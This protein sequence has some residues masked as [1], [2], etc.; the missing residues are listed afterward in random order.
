L[1]INVRGVEFDKSDG[2]S[3]R[4]NDEFNAAV[5]NELKRLQ[6]KREHRNTNALK[7]FVTSLDL[8]VTEL[9]EF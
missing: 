8:A 2:S 3:A 5:Q 4:N 1:N 6:R 7:E 9:W